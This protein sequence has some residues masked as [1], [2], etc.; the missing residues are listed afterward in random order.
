MAPERTRRQHATRGTVYMHGYKQA[1]LCVHRE[2]LCVYREVYVCTDRGEEREARR[3]LMEIR[4]RTR[5]L[6]QAY[7]KSTWLRDRAA[8]LSEIRGECRRRMGTMG[9]SK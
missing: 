6:H 2:V 1:Y 8:S 7:L 4:W 9:V 5:G 3:L